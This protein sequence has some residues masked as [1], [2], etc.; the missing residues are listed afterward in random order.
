MLGKKYAFNQAH[1]FVFINVWALT[2][3]PDIL[4]SSDY[5]LMLSITSRP[6]TK[7]KQFKLLGLEIVLKW[8][9]PAWAQIFVLFDGLGFDKSRQCLGGASTS[10]IEDQ[11]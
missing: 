7:V 2:L 11:P 9:L 1:S 5:Q 4:Y 10:T 3:G 6:I 8:L